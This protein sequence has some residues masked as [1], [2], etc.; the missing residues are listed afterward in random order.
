MRERCVNY[1]ECKENVSN[2]IRRGGHPRVPSFI[3]SFLS[4]I[5]LLMLTGCGLLQRR[6]V[7][8]APPSAQQT[9][10]AVAAAATESST[11]AT[12][13]PTDQERA[14]PPT[15]T[16]SP[17]PSESPVPQT[18]T[19]TL[20]PTTVPPSA[21]PIPPTATARPTASP[22][23]AAIFS[24]Q[25][26]PGEVDPGD[27]VTLSWEAAG[28][29]ATICPTASLALFTSDDCREVELSGTDTFVIPQGAAGITFIDFTL[30]VGTL[31][32]PAAETMQASVA[33]RC[34]RTWFY[35]DEPQAGICPHEAL[36]FPAAAQTF[37][38]GTMLWVDQ[39][40]SRYYILEQTRL[41]EG[42]VRRRLDIIH[43]PLQITGDTAGEIDPPEGLFAPESGFGLVWRGDVAESEGYRDRLGWALEPEF[44]YE[45]IFQCDNAPPS[46]GRS[47]Q[48]CYLSGPEARVIV[49]HPLGGWHYLDER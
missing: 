12:S 23:S 33:L 28:Q 35:S 26:S 32:E 48:T 16:P 10:T 14:T 15:A 21:T 5:G 31:A 9:P 34:H 45:T 18:A 47:W 1:R 19:P 30:T 27:T 11:I 22:V 29:T 24:F 7:G 4:V 37:E 6:A 40:P 8:T 44:G 20:A 38:R 3:I 41:V 17:E 43:D 25:A 49:L 36:H 46:G 42:D 13:T 39:L 2:S